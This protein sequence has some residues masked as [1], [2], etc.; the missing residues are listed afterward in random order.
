MSYFSNSSA[1]KKP[2]TMKKMFKKVKRI[3]SKSRYKDLSPSPAD[4]GPL[5]NQSPGL[6]ST[7]LIVTSNARPVVAQAP[8]PSSPSASSLPAPPGLGRHP[9]S[10]VNPS[11]P[12]AQPSIA[13]A[14]TSQVDVSQAVS[15]GPSSPA[16]S[17]DPPI[18]T[19]QP[20][21]A[22]P[23]TFT[24]PLPFS[25]SIAVPTPAQPPLSAGSAASAHV[26]DTSGGQQPALVRQVKD[27]PR[28]PASRFAKALGVAWNG[29][30][31]TLELLDKVSDANPF[32]KPI[33]GGVLA[34]VSAAEV[35]NL[36][37]FRPSNCLI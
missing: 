16:V 21:V 33:V 25:S 27:V 22:G 24:S 15:S 5:G 37:L 28:E 1:M 32:A 3:F 36:N 8:I 29:F 31:T 11:T 2:G 14:S 20:P 10:Q 12:L 9:F 13:R 18:H 23:P 30:R 7:P 35:R 26:D 34:L 19:T 17:P 4:P 6:P